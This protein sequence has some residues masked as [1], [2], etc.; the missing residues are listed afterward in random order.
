M[1]STAKA[2]PGAER[3]SERAEHRSSLFHSD[4]MEL[5][6]ENLKYGVNVSHFMATITSSKAGHIQILKGRGI[7]GSVRSGEVMAMLGHSGA[8]KV[9]EDVK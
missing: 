8:G 4:A 6:F 5:R 7:S 3:P 2:T 1:T 9:S